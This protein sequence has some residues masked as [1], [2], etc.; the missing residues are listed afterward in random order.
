MK[1][2]L[3]TGSVVEKLENFE[4]LRYEDQQELIRLEKN[5]PR[6]KRPV[7]PL[8][9]IPIQ[10]KE[11]VKDEYD[12]KEEKERE[13]LI[14]K[15]SKQFFSHRCYLEKYSIS[16]LQGFLKLNGCG[17]LVDKDAVRYYLII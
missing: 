3:Y 7:S 4:N 10:I 12:I 15:Q 11:E 1:C 13:A 17:K 14:A 2:K 5:I 9:A 16:E 6:L 8:V